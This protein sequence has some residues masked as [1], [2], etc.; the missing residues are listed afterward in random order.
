MTAT[1]RP[2]TENDL[3]AA[4]RIMSV[5]FGTFLGAPQP[6]EFWSDLDYVSTRWLA[7]PTSAFGAEIDG[8][9]VGSNFATRWG[10]VGFFGPLTVR[11][12]LWDQSVGK[13]L[14]QPIM[15]CFDKWKVT[16]AGLFTFA[17]SPKHIGLY[18]KY[19]FWPRF[20]TAIMSKPVQSTKSEPKWSKYSEGSDGERDG[21]LRA[22]SALT[23]SL[24]PG[25]NVEREIRA[26]R[27]QGLGETVLLWHD[28]ELVAFA[29]CHCG[30][31]TEAGTSKCYVKFGAVRPESAG[32]ELFS[33]LLDSCE[34]LAASKEMSR[35]EAGVNLARHEAYRVMLEHGFRTDIQGVAMQRFNQPGYNRPGVYLIDDWR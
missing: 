31:N 5:A 7:D 27:S 1:I 15:N 35:L 21:Y 3:A 13:Q 20:L 28:Q 12:D 17:H 32:G 33:R 29:V 11:P 6:D 14:M 19:D 2:L 4:R 30:P 9:L 16:H 10:S 8:E 23:D 22:C 25:L 18:Q 34:A 24:Y 26:V